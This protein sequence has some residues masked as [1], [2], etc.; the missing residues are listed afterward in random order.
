MLLPN[1]VDKALLNKPRD[2]EDPS[3]LGLSTRYRSVVSSSLLLSLP[4]GKG[5]GTRC[6]REEL[7]L[8]VPLLTWCEETSPKIPT[9]FQC[10]Q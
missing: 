7:V 9:L 2:N 8:K 6:V 5:P 10:R 1:I 3:S 4:L